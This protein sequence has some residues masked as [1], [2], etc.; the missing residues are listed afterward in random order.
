MGV[1]LRHFAFLGKLKLVLAVAPSV[2]R[3]VQTLFLTVALVLGLISGAHAWAEN[4]PP[5]E[6]P[7]ALPP[8][9]STLATYYPPPVDGPSLRLPEPATRL[10]ADG[11]LALSN[12]LSALPYIEGRGRNF[13][14]AVGG[15]WRWRRFAF[16]AEIPFLNVTTLDVDSV[17]NIQKADLARPSDA[18]QSSFAFGDIRV[19]ATWTT[20]LVGQQTLVGGLGFRTR[21]ATHTTKFTF[22]LADKQTEADFII[23]YYFHLE[24]TLILGGAFGRLTFVVNQGVIAL[25]GPDGNFD[26]QYI[27]VPSIYFWDAHYAIAYAPWSFLGASVELTTDI[28]LNHIAGVDFAKLND[29]RAA[30]VAPAL[31]IYFDE[32]RI[33]LIARIGLNRGQELL[34]VVEYVGTHS[35]TARLTRTFN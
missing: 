21:F 32:F 17:L 14:F 8:D 20:P 25:V 4:G 28:Q 1:M 30:W 11:S 26:Q 2:A 12:D 10:Y 33:D 27:V 23:P 5:G 13:R 6:V 15:V 29:I 34:G 35:F 9:D 18:H 31:Q 16:D 3:P 22:L 24:P 7:D 19:G